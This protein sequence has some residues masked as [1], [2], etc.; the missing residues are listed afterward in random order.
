MPA[1]VI[2]Y[3]CTS[4]L[5]IA[6]LSYSPYPFQWLIK[7]IPILLLLLPA[8]GVSSRK[9]SMLLCGAI[10]ASG[11]G[12][13]LLALPIEHSFT[14][15]LISFLIAHCLYIGAFLL[16]KKSNNESQL[17]HTG[18]QKL[19]VLPLLG[20]AGFALTMGVI[21]LPSTGSLLVPVAAYLCIITGMG[22]SAFMLRMPP[23]TQVGVVSFL[24]SDAA[25][26]YNLFNGPVAYAS[27]AVMSTYYVA[28]LLIIYGLANTVPSRFTKRR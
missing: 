21:I 11:S 8:S 27:V 7:V 6:S 28:Q 16:L 23:L 24:L 3:L 9:L 15:G 10:F 1:L 18:Q 22:L 5:Y 25:L 26:A 13:I 20:I 4:T 19:T 17:D 12:D 2:T 14:Y